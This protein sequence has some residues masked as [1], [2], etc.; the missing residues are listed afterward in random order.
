MESLKLRCCVVC[1]GFVL[2]KNLHSISRFSLLI[3]L[4]KWKFPWK[5][6]DKSEQTTPAPSLGLQVVCYARK[7]VQKNCPA[8]G[9]CSC[10]RSLVTHGHF[11]APDETTIRMG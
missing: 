9:K 1:G 2:S 3:P 8:G 10:K 11:E 5:V 4:S 6:V 7:V